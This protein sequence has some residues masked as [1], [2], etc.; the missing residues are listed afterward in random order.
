MDSVSRAISQ[1]NGWLVTQLS[2]TIHYQIYLLTLIF[3]I[4]AYLSFK[5]KK[6]LISLALSLL[7]L[8]T[9]TQLLKDYYKTPRPCA[10]FPAKVECPGYSSFP[11]GHMA[12]AAAFL[13]ASLGTA[14]FP[15]YFIFAI[16]TAFSRIYLGVHFFNDVVGGLALGF[17]A[18]AISERVVN[19]FLKK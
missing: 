15:F 9:A 12:F 17:V 18:Y 5:E 8:I 16:F 10:E 3:F 6:K 13:A 19:W 2:L 11:S 7:L 4:I 14:I 1:M